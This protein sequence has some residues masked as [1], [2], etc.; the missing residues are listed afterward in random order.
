V[1]PDDECRAQSHLSPDLHTG[2]VFAYEYSFP[3]DDISPK[4]RPVVML[5]SDVGGLSQHLWFGR[6][7]DPNNEVIDLR[8]FVL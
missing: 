1:L 6:Y 5:F 2:Q 7:L 8:M 3:G 4:E